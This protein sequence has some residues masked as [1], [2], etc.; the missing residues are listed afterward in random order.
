MWIKKEDY[1]KLVNKIKEL[2]ED[3]GISVARRMFNLA[4]ECGIQS[5]SDEFQ[6]I[7]SRLFLDLAGRES[8]VMKT[9]SATSFLKDT[10]EELM[11]RL[12]SLKQEA[13]ILTKKLEFKGKK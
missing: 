13:S 2:E 1:N 5:H 10:D 9:Y 6:T 11:D 12:K 4:K 7:M 3:K 8:P